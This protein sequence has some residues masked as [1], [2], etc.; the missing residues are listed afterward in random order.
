MERTGK[1]GDKAGQR[2]R[3]DF[4]RG[5]DDTNA[6]RHVRAYPHC[7]RPISDEDAET[8]LRKRRMSEEN[9]VVVTLDDRRL[10]YA[11]FTTVDS[12][13]TGLLKSRRFCYLIPIDGDPGDREQGV[14]RALM[15]H[16]R[17][18][19]RQA[20]IAKIELDV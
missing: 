9:F 14:G 10:G 6:R 18:T 15:R 5:V 1:D 12:P 19:C 16:V 2:I 17:E 20:G 13:A 4:H 3:P 11:I 7:H 8:L